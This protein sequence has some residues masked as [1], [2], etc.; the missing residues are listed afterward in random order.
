MEASRSADGLRSG[1]RLSRRRENSFTQTVP[2]S[3]G[4]W[5]RLIFLRVLTARRDLFQANID[6]VSAL[7]EL[8]IATVEIEGL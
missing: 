7:T 4:E 6:S 1:G 3:S 5:V 8:H 2:R